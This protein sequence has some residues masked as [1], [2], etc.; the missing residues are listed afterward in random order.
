[1]TLCNAA[2]TTFSDHARPTKVGQRNAKSHYGRPAP[3]A[4]AVGSIANLSD[5]RNSFKQPKT[6]YR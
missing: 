1:M 2:S 6:R 5:A 3:E 4:L